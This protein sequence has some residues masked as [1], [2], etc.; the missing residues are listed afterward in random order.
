[1]K[2]DE[3]EARRKYSVVAKHYHNWRTKVHPE[4]WFY[5]EM[6]EMPAT[7]ELLGN[8]KGKK[9]LDFGCGTG[10]YAKEM[11]A[12]RAK[13]KGFDISPEMLELAKKVNPKLDLRL[14]SGYKI[15]FKEKFDIVVASLVIEHFKDWDKV[16]GQVKS[17]LKKGG[18]FIFSMDN[19]VIEATSKTTKKRAMVRKF[20][21]YFAEKKTYGRWSNI[22]HKNEVKNVMMPSYHKTY[23]TIIKTILKQGFEIVDYKDCFPLKKAKKLFP[24]RYRFASRIPYFCV[25]KIAKK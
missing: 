23:E 3:K 7:F 19:P 4:G 8:L 11:T 12:R 1:M 20:E 18:V 21:D 9:V 10:I 6:L 13:V 15:P 17:V 2:P 22:L 25:W 24:R 14:G 16:F 5:N